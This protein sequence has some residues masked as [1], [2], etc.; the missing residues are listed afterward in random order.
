MPAHGRELI[1]QDPAY[2]ALLGTLDAF[3][4]K[5]PAAR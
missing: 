1:A 5:I 4:A 2:K 3:V